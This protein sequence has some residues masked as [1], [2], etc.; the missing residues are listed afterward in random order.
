MA[1]NNTHPSW[2]VK[3]DPE[4]SPKIA[5]EHFKKG[6]SIIAVCN[7]LGIVSSTYYQWVEHHP[8][9]KD[10]CQL[11]LQHSQEFYEDIGLDGIRGDLEKFGGSSWQFVMK[12]R[13]RHS[14]SDQQQNDINVTLI[15]KLLAS[16]E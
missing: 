14:Y 13:F 4:T 12:N 2:L 11:G 8:E 5:L 16:K 3:Y 15:E 7:K 6:K 1:A 9:F 10:A